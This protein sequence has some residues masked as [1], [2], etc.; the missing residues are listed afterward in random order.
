MRFS[1]KKFKLNRIIIIA[2][3]KELTILSRT[4]FAIKV[5]KDA[6]LKELKI[7]N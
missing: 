6:D 5:R 3:F 2:K 7:V 4:F 1:D